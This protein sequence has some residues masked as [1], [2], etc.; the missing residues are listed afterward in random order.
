MQTDARTV[1]LT[2]AEGGVAYVISAPYMYDAA[3]EYSDAVTLTLTET[4][5][6]K[7]TLTLT[8]ESEWLGD[9]SRAYPVCIDPAFEYEPTD[10]DTVYET[11]GVLLDY[12]PSFYSTVSENAYVKVGSNYIGSTYHELVTLSYHA[13]P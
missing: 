9:A 8:A 1:T 7:F 6:K 4:K 5:N 12:T 3:G 2:D 10:A 11:T 13:L